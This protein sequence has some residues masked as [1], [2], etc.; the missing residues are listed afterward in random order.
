MMCSLLI[1]K[2]NIDF[3]FF[4]SDHLLLMKNANWTLNG[5]VLPSSVKQRKVKLVLSEH[6]QKL[7]EKPTIRMLVFKNGMG[8]HGRE[9]AAPLDQMEKVNL[10]DKS[11]ITVKLQL[12]YCFHYLLSS[13]YR[14]VIRIE[15][16]CR[17]F[18]NNATHPP[19]P[20]SL[21]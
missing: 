1:L 17:S 4:L 9:I 11:T 13:S 14:Y 8:Q 7:M 15:I 3:T 16:D 20:T 10:D 5:L 21:A 12:S 6:I 19:H 2:P 18:K